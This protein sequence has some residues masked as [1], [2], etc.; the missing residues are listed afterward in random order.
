MKNKKVKI[1]VIAVVIIALLA[2]IFAGVYLT[3]KVEVILK[4]EPEVTV[5]N[6]EEYKDE[7]AEASFSGLMSSF[8]S[9]IASSDIEPKSDVNYKKPGDYK[10]TYS[11]RFLYIWE[12]HADR[13]VHVKDTAAPVITLEGDQFLNGVVPADYQ[14]QGF[15]AVDDYDGDVTD[16]VVRTVEEDAVVYTV[17]DSSGNEA[18]AE[19]SIQE[20]TENVIY[21][22]F[23]DGPGQYTQELLD[24]LA[25]HNVKATFFVTAAGD[26]S[27][28]KKEAEAGHSIAVHTYS[29]E[30]SQI[31]SSEAA[32][33]ADFEKMENIIEQQTGKRTKLFRFPGGSSNTV[34]KNYCPGIMTALT[35]HMTEKG[36]VYFD[37]NVVSGD[38]GETTDT[39]QVYQNIIGGIQKNP[40]SVVLQ[41]DIKGFSVAAVE[42]V[43]EWG[44]ANGYVFLPLTTRSPTAH[45]TVLN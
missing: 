41:H 32:Y 25:K 8:S 21:L 19:R 36:Y 22:T 23:D 20:P 9:D 7:G 28:I 3:S 40:A 5:T 37:W 16:K 24:I 38:A 18:K 45:Q 17:K 4:G 6:L 14:E 42:R 2:G 12:G 29:H 33:M 15:K 30:Y 44:K 1:A 31:Y 11:A 10:I 26:S 34:S 43:I 27:L 39:E 13:I 35:Q